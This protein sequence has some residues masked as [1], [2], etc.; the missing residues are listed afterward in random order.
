MSSAIYHQLINKINIPACLC[1]SSGAVIVANDTGKT[2]FDPS[3]RGTLH[4]WLVDNKLSLCSITNTEDLTGSITLKESCSGNLINVDK[5]DE[6]FLITASNKEQASSDGKTNLSTFDSFTHLPTKALLIDRLEQTIIKSKRDNKSVALISCRVERF[7]EYLTALGE[8]KSDELKQSIAERLLECVRDSDTVAQIN[9]KTFAMVFQVAAAQD[10]DIIARKVLRKLEEPIQVSGQEISVQL[11][12]GISLFPID[13]ES[14]QELLD[15]AHTAMEHARIDG[16]PYQ[17]F[18]S[19]MNDKAKFRI[20]VE[21]G[22]RNAL[23]NR[24]F[25]LYYQPKIEAKSAKIVGAEG[26]I[27]WHDEQLGFVSPVQF[28]PI[29][30]VTGLIEDIGY[31][32]IQEAC[33]QSLKWQKDGLPPIRIS[34]NVSSRQ[35]EAHNFIE[36]LQSIIKLSKIN[37]ALLELEITE[38][39]LIRNIDKTIEVFHK[40]REVGCHLSIDDFGTGYSNLSYLTR[41]PLTTLKIDRAFIKDLE[42]NRNTAEVAK[43]IIGLSRGL[44]LEVVAEG[45]ETIQHVNFLMENGCETVQGYYYSKPVPAEK[46]ELMLSDSFVWQA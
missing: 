23:Q 5:A 20:Y 24:I 6:L 35:L 17:F 33:A 15:C 27:R 31:W 9:F 28:I 34:V 8:H 26:L 38:S 29:A 41:F 25:Q 4:D 44:N 36:R 18:A 42:K 45:A 46:F 7:D 21:N 13:G 16:E 30:E 10:A 19:A 32:V 22:M 40:I 12:M 3:K 43:A 37:P 1:D 14:A 2:K 11:I 39:M